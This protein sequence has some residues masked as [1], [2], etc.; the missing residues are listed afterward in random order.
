MQLDLLSIQQDLPNG[1]SYLPDFISP[2]EEAALLK[3]IRPL[4]FKE[5]KY[6]SFSAKRRV[7]RFGTEL[8]EADDEEGDFPRISFPPFLGALRDRVARWLALPAAQFEHGLITEYPPGAPIGWHR[9]A[10]QFEVIAGVS[11]GSPCDMRFRPFAAKSAREALSLPLAPR[12]VYVMR[13]DIRWRWQ[14]GIGPL[15]ETRYS[16]TLRTMALAPRPTA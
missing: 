7:V 3:A 15:A 8:L 10:P 1:L 11:L 2:A 13:G 16:I 9:D 5:A 4:E 14:H 6:K 12:S